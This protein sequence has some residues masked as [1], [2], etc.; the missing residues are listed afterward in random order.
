M[1]S[2]QSM[3]GPLASRE[4]G[5]ALIL[6][7]L[8]VVPI[9]LL[10]ALMV[11]LG[12]AY[13]Q[14]RSTQ[15]LADN[16]AMA[17][18]DIIGKNLVCSGTCPDGTT[19]IQAIC[20]VAINSDGMSQNATFCGGTGVSNGLSVAITATYLDSSG[21]SL[22]SV[23][24]GAIPGS[25]RGLRITSSKDSPAFFAQVVGR[26]SFPVTS[27][28][29][30]LTNDITGYNQSAANYG[31]F[32]VWYTQAVVGG[33]AIY[34]SPQWCRT[35]APNDL[36]CASSSFKGDIDH[37]SGYVNVGDNVTSSGS[38]IGQWRS[39][40]QTYYANGWD[41]IMPVVNSVSSDGKPTIHVIGFVAV[42][43]NPV[44]NGNGGTFSGTVVG[45]VDNGGS[46]TGGT[47][48]PTLP[49][50]QQVSLIQ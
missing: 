38:A 33:T 37:G 29:A 28:A 15:N 23:T 17:G 2:R 41:V 46:V 36:N 32:A 49:Q 31:P 12:F 43:L 30:A 39:M 42:K 20:N 47:V 3:A 8:L 40:L 4:R 10:L 27:Q 44:P 35:V 48:T 6:F 25:A 24:D 19:V 21:T 5:Q 22:G 18:A 50:L 7:T 26:R 16:A 14:K 34:E 45:W 1:A 11:D 13:G 9:A